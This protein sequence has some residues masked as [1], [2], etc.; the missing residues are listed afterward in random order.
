MDQ[1]TSLAQWRTTNEGAMFWYWG[2]F[3]FGLGVLLAFSLRRFNELL[4]T[5]SPEA[6]GPP[7]SRNRVIADATQAVPIGIYRLLSCV[8]LR[9]SRA[10]LMPAA[11]GMGLFGGLTSTLA[12]SWATPAGPLLVASFLVGV[13]PNLPIV[14][15]VEHAVRRIGHRIAG[16]PDNL[17]QLI[18]EV[19]RSGCIGEQTII[20]DEKSLRADLVETAVVTELIGVPEVARKAIQANLTHAYLL[21]TWV[22][23]EQARAVRSQDPDPFD[24]ST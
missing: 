5:P 3:V 9:L 23:T 12:N 14:E 22:H 20:A 18:D 2:A 15:E 10:L 1:S 8:C 19:A 4:F 16:I 7:A 21:G 11:R 17:L 6:C 13:L 24:A